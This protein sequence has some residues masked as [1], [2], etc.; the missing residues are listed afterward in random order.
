MGKF[1]DLRTKKYIE[2]QGL[3][4]NTYFWR[5]HAQQKI[6][7][8]EE[9]DGILHPFEFKWNENKKA[10]IPATFATSYPQQTFNMVTPANYTDFLV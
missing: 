10:K 2:Y 7:H 9:R 5:T 6:D 1:H 8:I 3:Y 4:S